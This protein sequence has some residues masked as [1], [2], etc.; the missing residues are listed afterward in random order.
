MRAES[1]S[2][3]FFT[4][5]H[6]R[7]IFKWTADAQSLEEPTVAKLN[8]F[9]DSSVSAMAYRHHN[10]SLVSTDTKKLYVTDLTRC[11]TPKAKLVSN[12]I[13]QIHV[14]PQT[15]NM[16]LLEVRCSVNLQIRTSIYFTGPTS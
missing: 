8:V 3:E 7:R 4:G 16:T 6:D 1:G 2:V 9:L 11:Y 12:D 10:N 5:G 13:H 14:H 15:P